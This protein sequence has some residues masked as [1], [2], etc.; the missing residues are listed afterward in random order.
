MNSISILGSTGSIG[1][2]TLE[3]IAANPEQFK[4]AAL[5]ANK[6]DQLLEK[7]IEQ[8][9]PAIAVLTD[10]KAGDRLLKRY[11]GRTKIL[12]GEAGLM[13]A[14]TYPNT[15]M[16]LTAVVGFAGLKPT[17]A[18]IEAKKNIALANK[19]TLV[20]AGEIV[21]K[22]AQ[23]YGVKILPVDS[24]H[25]AIL[26]CLGDNKKFVERLIITASGG[27]FR[28]F[29]RAELENVT[30][31]SCLKHPNWSMGKKITVDSATLVNKG[32]EVIE[33]RWLFD[34]PFEKISVLIH[35]QS[36]VHSMVEYIDGAVLA[37]LGMP[38]MR[39]PIQYALTYPERK[40][41]NFPKLDLTQYRELTFSHPDIKTFPALAE[42]YEVG[43]KGGTLPCVLNA[44]NEV[45]VHNFLAGKI[46]FLDIMEIIRAT[47][48]AH[49]VIFQP[50]LKD[51]FNMDA[52]ARGYAAH[53]I[54]Q[55]KQ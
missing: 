50:T 38:D 46:K 15:D 2:Q 27:P 14:A 28:G 7:Q 47:L 23:K 17:L 49:K 4:I 5:T 3:V 19:E 40:T 33:A 31:E 10:Q 26:Q 42:A 54:R 29:T 22:A 13:E 25:S 48:D 53:I 24:E 39:T 6:N 20:A 12:V 43:K 37:Q 34:L 32:L 8:F 55:N 51:I 9:K 52:W 45:A 1:T 18:A 44:A 30:V 21:T 11:K 16:V 36:I 35:P 41:A